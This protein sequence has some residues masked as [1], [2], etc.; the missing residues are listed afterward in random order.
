[1]VV[2]RRRSSRNTATDKPNRSERRDPPGDTRDGRSGSLPDPSPV[3]DP[4]ISLT[5]IRAPC[6]ASGRAYSWPN[7]PPAPVI[8]ATRSSD[9]S[10]FFNVTR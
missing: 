7:P 9:R 6:D 5:T 4:P 1:V 3:T 2:H 8:T 10:S